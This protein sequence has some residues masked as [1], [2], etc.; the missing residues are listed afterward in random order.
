M[1]GQALDDHDPQA[2]DVGVHA[3]LL[4]I[5]ALRRH[6]RY[7]ADESLPLLTRLIRNRAN[8]EVSNLNLPFLVDEDVMRFDIAMND[9]LHLVQVLKALQD[10]LNQYHHDRLHNLALSLQDYLQG[11]Q[12]HVLQQ[13][14]YLSLLP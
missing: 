2:P 3:I 8:T 12:V 6:K 9:L 1:P 10:L 4:P 13:D 5:H 14:E 7:S 11:A